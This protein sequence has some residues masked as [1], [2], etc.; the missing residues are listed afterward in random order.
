M[1]VNGKKRAILNTKKG[2]EEVEVLKLAKYEKNMKKYI[3]DKN[4]KKTIFVKDRLIN[5]IVNE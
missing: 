1:Q 5:F 2:I 3:N 4:I